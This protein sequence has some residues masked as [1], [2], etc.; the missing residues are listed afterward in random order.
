MLIRSGFENPVRTIQPMRGIRLGQDLARID[1]A[2]FDLAKLDQALSART[3]LAR[4]ETLR[5]T[6]FL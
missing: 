5:E 3:P 6:V 4:R 2:K 1:P